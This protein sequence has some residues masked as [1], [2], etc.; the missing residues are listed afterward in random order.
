M[1]GILR[2]FSRK[3]MEAGN[4]SDPVEIFCRMVIRP[5]F[6]GGNLYR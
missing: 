4:G 5:F 6:A 2:K 3:D 1:R